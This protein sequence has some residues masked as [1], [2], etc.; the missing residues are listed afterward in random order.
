MFM[1]NKIASALLFILLGSGCANLSAQNTFTGITP[2]Q[3]INQAKTLAAQGKWGLTADDL[4]DVVIQDLVK[5]PTGETHAYVLQTLSGI[6]V[7]NGV[8]GLHFKSNGNLFYAN[9]RAVA[10][11][12]DKLQGDFSSLNTQILGDIALKTAFAA[13]TDIP[14]S[15]TWETM[16]ANTRFAEGNFYAQTVAWPDASGNLIAAK[17]FVFYQPITSDWVNLW[18][19][20]QGTVL[21]KHS[22]TVHCA[23][24]SFE[25]S[26]HES[27]SIHTAGMVEQSQQ[28]R[29]MVL[30]GQGKSLQ[31]R[32]DG[33]TYKAY[34]FPTESPLYGNPSTLTSPADAQASP[35]GWHDVNGAAGAEYTITR[36]TM[37][38]LQKMLMPITKQATVPAAELHWPSTL[39]T[40][41]MKLIR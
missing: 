7:V 8:V 39:P 40:A 20:A 12:T 41:K 26:P 25:Q 24:A 17:Y 16:K 2:T 10:H 31:R 23:P 22:W 15:V 18:I 13:P 30:N 4:K 14:Q 27:H 1:K 29:S 34:A 5:D 33:A 38:L 35:Y 21:Q 36:G 9:S 3:A 37:C 28:I 19:D 11:A 6:P 32:G